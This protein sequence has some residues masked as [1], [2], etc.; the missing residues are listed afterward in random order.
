MWFKDKS[1]KVIEI[2]SMYR[3]N[4]GLVT[5]ATLTAALA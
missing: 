3:T 2:T 5:V 1:I 4:A